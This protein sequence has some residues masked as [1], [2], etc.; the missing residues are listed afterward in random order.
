[1]IVRFVIVKSVK[2]QN[3]HYVFSKQSIVLLLKNSLRLVPSLN[4]I[5][6]Y[7]FL[8]RLLCFG[9]HHEGPFVTIYSVQGCLYV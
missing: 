8:T 4:C 3:L 2:L 9:F 5:Y 6:I 7:M 1:M